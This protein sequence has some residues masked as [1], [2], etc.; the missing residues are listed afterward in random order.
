MASKSEEYE[1]RLFIDNQFIHATSGKTLTVKNPVNGSIVGTVEAA[2]PE[3]VDAAVD[4]ATAAF[5]EEW[6]TFT[7][8]QRKNCI[9]KLA[10]IIEKR[11]LEL[12]RAETA[13][14]GLP[15]MFAQ[16]LIYPGSLNMLRANSGSADKIEGQSYTDQEDGFYKV[17][18]PLQVLLSGCMEACGRC[19]L[20]ASRRTPLDLG[21]NN[22]IETLF[23]CFRWE[24]DFGTAAGD[25]R[26]GPQSET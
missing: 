8:H 21:A 10:D 17:D 9:A 5:K 23:T 25:C 7:G 14:V 22:T 15:I 1:S 2:G 16:H 12:A 19:G 18:N 3:D 11:I 26:R 6:A 4:T 20:Y 24:H 13:S